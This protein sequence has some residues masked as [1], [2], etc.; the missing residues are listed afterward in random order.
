MRELVAF[1]LISGAAGCSATTVSAT[2]DASDATDAPDVTDRLAPDIADASAPDIVARDMPEPRDHTDATARCAWRAGESRDLVEGVPAECELLDLATGAEGSWILWACDDRATARWSVRVARLR[3]DGTAVGSSVLATE[4]T[5]PTWLARAALAVDDARD[6][7]AALLGDATQRPALQG[8]GATTTPTWTTTIAQPA[9]TFPLDDLRDPAVTA[10]G[11]SVIGDQ[12][13]ALWGTTLVLTDAMGATQRG[14]DL[15]LAADPF[16]E[17]SRFGMSD[18]GFSLVLRVAGTAPRA[19][20]R[21]YDAAGA[22]RGAVMEL[23]PLARASSRV[24]IRP[25]AV[26]AIAL[27]DS[28]LGP[29]L[30]GINVDGTLATVTQRLTTLPPFSADDADLAVSQGD[31][32]LAATAGS[33]VLRTVVQ[34]LS[35]GGATLGTILSLGLAEPAPGRVRIVPTR[36]GA[37]VAHRRSATV[38]TLTPLTCAP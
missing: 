12:V 3:D 19:L 29:S 11:F 35:R 20:V 31:V 4:S 28:P 37:L 14:V 18:G 23:G 34:P 2:S 21:R 30:R 8:F 26:A 9:G 25:D 7:R 16:G 5:R 32:L 36:S 1:L 13:R 38:I 24:W 22:P 6:R 33:G 27:W 17:V 15:D 10:D